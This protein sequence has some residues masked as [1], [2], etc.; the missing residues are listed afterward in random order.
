MARLDVHTGMHMV[1]RERARLESNV[2]ALIAQ[3]HRYAVLMQE[4]DLDSSIVELIAM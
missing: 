4:E 3:L 1:H 2:A